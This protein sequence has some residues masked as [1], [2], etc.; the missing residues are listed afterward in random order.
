MTYEK[1]ERC[2]TIKAYLCHHCGARIHPYYSGTLS[3][4]GVMPWWRDDDDSMKCGEVLHYPTSQEAQ[5]L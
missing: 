3:G 5:E 1:C 4:G 2:G